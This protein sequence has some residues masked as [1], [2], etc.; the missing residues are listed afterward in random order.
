MALTSEWQKLDKNFRA[1]KEGSKIY[2][3]F[4]TNTSLETFMVVLSGQNIQVG[5]ESLTLEEGEKVG[6]TIAIFDAI[7]EV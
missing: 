7:F 3:G 5:I 2:V 4:P 6:E 1:K